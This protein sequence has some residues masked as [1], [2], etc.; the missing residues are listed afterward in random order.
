MLHFNFVT[1]ARRISLAT[2]ELDSSVEAHCPQIPGLNLQ[3][4]IRFRHI[5]LGGRGRGG[6]VRRTVQ[7]RGE[8][9]RRPSHP[10]SF[11]APLL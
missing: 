6:M 7:G 9:G 5:G 8:P 11:P 1:H 2:I 4:L 3:F 10:R